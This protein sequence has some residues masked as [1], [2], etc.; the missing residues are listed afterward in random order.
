[1]NIDDNTYY[2]WRKDIETNG[3]SEDKRPMSVH[4]VPANKMSEEEVKRILAV[5]H[6][7]ENV[8]KS[9]YEVF[10]ELLD[11]GEYIGSPSTFYRYLRLEGETK[12]R[13]VRRNNGGGGKRPTEWIA[14]QRLQIIVWDIALL[15]TPIEGV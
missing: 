13:S 7:P 4:P 3:F 9:C 1:M 12:R 14:T 5:M 11:Q 10:Y 6:T 2:R 15:P 8:D